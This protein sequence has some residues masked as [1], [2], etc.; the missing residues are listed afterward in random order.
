M[1]EHETL[2]IDRD[3]FPEALSSVAEKTEDSL[4]VELGSDKAEGS[5]RIL[6]TIEDYEKLAN[7]R[8]AFD[9]AWGVARRTKTVVPSAR[10]LAKMAER[11][12]AEARRLSALEIKPVTRKT[13]D[14]RN[15]LPRILRL[16]PLVGQL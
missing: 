7:P 12:P 1:C 4:R 9:A 16:E 3:F 13:L 2:A 5:G 11:M 10:Q 15:I 14:V 8:S 6:V